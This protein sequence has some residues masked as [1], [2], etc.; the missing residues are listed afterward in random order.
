MFSNPADLEV[1]YF[2]IVFAVHRSSWMMGP[3]DLVMKRN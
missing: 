3:S 2:G 1:S